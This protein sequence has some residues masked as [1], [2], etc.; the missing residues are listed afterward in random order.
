MKLL[1]YQTDDGATHAGVLTDAGVLDVAAVL[2][3]VTGLRDVQAVLELPGEPLAELRARLTHTKVPPVPLATVQLRAPILRPP[4]I[5]DFMAYEGHATFSGSRPQSEAWYRLPVFYFSNTLCIHGSDETVPLPSA[6][7]R[8]DFELEIAVVIGKEGRNIAA[9]DAMDYIAG[10]TIFNDWSCRDLQRDEMQVHLGPAKSKDFATS[11]GPW[12]VTPD[13]LAAMLVDQR[14]KVRG[15]LSVNGEQWV[16]S[17]CGAMHHN[18]GDLIER[19]SRDSRIVPGD[20][21]GGGTVGGGCILELTRT[22]GGPARFLKAGD[23]V[24]IEVDGLG[25]LRNTL[26]PAPIALGDYR[27]AV[28]P[29]A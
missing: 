27:Y 8:V 29:R 17:D 20:I 21:L 4:T 25:T 16:D 22:P 28:P 10:F 15:R 9:A 11:I 3:R 2:G 6:S 18:W 24:E 19:A 5:R 13:E 1:T 26:T 23:V 14:L 7:K 12:M